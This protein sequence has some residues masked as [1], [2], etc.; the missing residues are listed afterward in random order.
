MEID[1]QYF[2]ISF[3]ITL[4]WIYLFSPPPMVIVHQK[5]YRR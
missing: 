3:T 4:F 5:K 1:L 2:I